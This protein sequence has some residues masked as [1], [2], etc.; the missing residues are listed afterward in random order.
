MRTPVTPSALYRDPVPLNPV[1]HRDKRVGQLS[2]FSVAKGLHAVYLAA[3]EFE[4]AALEYVIVFVP[5][6]DD[7]ATGKRRVAPIVVLG[8]HLGENLFVDGT[9]WDAHYMPAFIRR[10]PFWAADLS[11]GSADGPPICIDAAW[12]GW[13]DTVGDRVFEADGTPAPALTRAIEFMRAFE[14]EVLRTNALCSVLV[15]QNLLRDMKADAT[16]PDGTALALNGFFAVDPEKLQALPDATVVELHRNG[17]LALL[18]M[19]LL[20]L[21]NLRPMIDRKVRRLAAGPAA[22]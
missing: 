17:I 7:S 19:H 15:E 2:D 3:A 6:G 11:G 21:A 18:Q 4:H 22:S 9:R 14:A 1:L 5:T 13:S 10:Y 8:L 16:L 12:S 20:S